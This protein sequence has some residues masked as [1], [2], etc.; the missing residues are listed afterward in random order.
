MVDRAE[1]ERMRF[2]TSRIGAL[3]GVAGLS[4]VLS[5]PSVA[6]IDTLPLATPALL[7][8]AQMTSGSAPELRVVS[9]AVTA[10]PGQERGWQAVAP[11]LTGAASGR[12]PRLA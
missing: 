12:M 3:L 4:L 1:R 10:T 8:L 9:F 7:S 2:P 11:G 6:G 5:S